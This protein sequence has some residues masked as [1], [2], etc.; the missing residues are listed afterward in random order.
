MHHFVD[1]IGPERILEV[2]DQKLGYQGAVVI[3]NTALGPGKGGIRLVPDIELKEIFSLAR[4][5]TYK[6]A[7]ADIPFGGAKAGIKA[8]PKKID[9]EKVI[10]SFARLIK[11]LI[12]E[13]YIPGP[14][15]NTTEKE[16][17]YIADELKNKKA[18][19]GKPLEM[20][21]LPHELGSTGFG[22]AQATKI[23]MDFLKKN[24][25]ECTIA[26]EG[27]GN[28]G[29]F[30]H[31][32]LEEMGAKVVALSDSKGAVYNK[33]GIKY[34]EAMEIKQKKGTVTEYDGTKMDGSKLFELEVDILIPGARPNVINEKNYQ[35]VK[36][37]LIVEA[38]N[39]PISHEIEKKLAKKKILIIPDFVANAGGVISSYAEYIGM[40]KE[41]MFKLVERK[42]KENTAKVLERTENFD[43]RTAALGI[44]KQKVLDAMKNK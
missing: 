22:V 23:G 16:M 24:L 38:A 29:T 19:T 11:P 20:G 26:I 43:T 44:A 35:K 8:E 33:N 1:E 6:N 14:D 18:A 10:R 2:Y 3:D 4:A 5:M 34:Q 41:E 39:L 27:Y 13:Y 17:G 25:D 30:T 32:F 42:I 9:K 15:M 40:N 7:M 12:P 37:K 31:K 28:V 21:G 36:S